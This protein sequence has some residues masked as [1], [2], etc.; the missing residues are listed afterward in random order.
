M[1]DADQVPRKPLAWERPGA[2]LPF[3]ARLPMKS[4]QSRG[5]RVVSIVGE[6]HEV[7][8]DI[9]RIE[10]FS[11]HGDYNEMLGYLSCQ[12]KQQL[13]KVFLV[14]GDAEAQEFYKGEMQKAGFTNIEIPAQGD[15][16]E[17]D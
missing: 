9:E 12:D 7:N 2:C 3:L 8:A 10:A 4:C 6:Q 11:G 15:S 5:D 1:A 13:K 17:L 16:F 14:H